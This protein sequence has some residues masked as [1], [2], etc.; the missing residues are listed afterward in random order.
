[1]LDEHADSSDIAATVI[2]LAVRRYVWITPVGS[3]DW[4]IDRVNAPDD[5]LRG[6]EKAVYRA[7][8]PDGTDSV[9]VGELRTPGRVQS[10]PVRT[11][12]LADAVERGAFIDRGRIG[13]PI[14]LGGALIVGG[15]V[16]TIAL[17]LTSGS[18]LVGVAILLAGFATTLLPRFLPVRTAQGRE[19]VGR[20]RALQRGLDA[21]ARDQIPPADQE[22]VFSRALPFM[23]IGGR[24]D[25]WIRAFRDLNLA[26]DSQPGL[27]WFG[28]FERDRNLQRFA[29]HFPYFITA[30]EALFA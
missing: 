7:L 16:A 4:R 19:L 22:L 1:M 30:L 27:Y 20:I 15:I 13:L 10:Q 2:D 18:A 23:V 9:T 5:Q 12:M 6:Y 8:L 29:G 28:T 14:L 24:A 3:N 21:T 11:A 26:A 17:A 25:N